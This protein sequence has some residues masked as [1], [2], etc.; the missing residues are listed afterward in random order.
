MMGPGAC[1]LLCPSLLLPLPTMASLPPT[2]R[3][4][5]EMGRKAGVEGASILG[6]PL[7]ARGQGPLLP[8]AMVKANNR[9]V[10]LW[11]VL[12]RRNA[13]GLP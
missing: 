6:C 10:F 4:P 3:G 11:T 9:R 12:C 7:V 1:V 2:E 8:K 13:D 5:S